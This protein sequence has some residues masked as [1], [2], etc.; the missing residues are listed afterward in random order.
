M[1]KII[2]LFLVIISSCNSTDFPN[3]N[4]PNEN[5]NLKSDFKIIGHRGGITGANPDNSLAALKGAIAKNYDM[6]EI[7]IRFTKDGI[8]I[9]HHDESLSDLYNVT[10]HPIS[11]LSFEE[12]LKIKKDHGGLLPYTLDEFAII[13][14]GKVGFLLDFKGEIYKDSY[15]ENCYKTLI[16][17][18]IKTIKV[19]WSTSAKNYFHKKEKVR[20]ALSYLEFSDAYMKSDFSPDWYY[21]HISSYEFN[22]KL[23]Q[24]A[25]ELNLE[26]VVSVNEWNYRQRGVTNFKIITEDIYKMIDTGVRFFLIDSVFYPLFHFEK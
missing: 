15:Y 11:S 20:T 4:H 13:S 16:K 10:P 5:L 23:I 6:V 26:V 8:P 7:D 21:L 3:E 12:I 24:K 9:L 22:P 2:L 17:H 18:H 14:E 1:K 19:A 25:L